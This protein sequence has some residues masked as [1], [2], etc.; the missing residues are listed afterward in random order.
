M[1]LSI[2]FDLMMSPEDMVWVY[3]EGGMVEGTVELG[4]RYVSR[5]STVRHG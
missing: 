4:H 5:V 3:P 2:E 1:S